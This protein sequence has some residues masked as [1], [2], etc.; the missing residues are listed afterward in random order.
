[1]WL[2]VVIILSCRESSSRMKKRNASISPEKSSNRMSN[3][4]GIYPA[5]K[6]EEN[7]QPRDVVL[8]CCGC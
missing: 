1:M 7:Q 3:F 8:E 5:S 2:V 4:N 6:T